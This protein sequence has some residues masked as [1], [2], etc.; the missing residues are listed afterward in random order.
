ME[1]LTTLGQDVEVSV[2]PGKNAGAGHM[3]VTVQPG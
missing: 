2:K 3:S 1:F